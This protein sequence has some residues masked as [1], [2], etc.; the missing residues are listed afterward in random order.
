MDS[1]F[2]ALSTFAGV[3][4]A[5]T[6]VARQISLGDEKDES[7]G[8]NEYRRW[9]SLSVTYE[10]GA[11]ALFGMLYFARKVS[12]HGVSMAG[13]F[14]VLFSLMGLGLYCAYFYHL[15]ALRGAIGLKWHEKILV[16]LAL[17]PMA[18]FV[19]VPMSFFSSFSCIGVN[20]FAA[21]LAWLVLSGTS[22]SLIWY[23]TSWERP[24]TDGC[25]IEVP[26]KDSR[27]H[28]AVIK[29]VVAVIAVR[30]CAQASHSRK[31]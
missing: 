9:D 4:F 15:I 7:R 29:M 20:W 23:A 10:L 28:A 13:V 30:S 2:L 16:P 12:L 27:F 14:S 24:D 3:L 8:H 17:V 25:K 26:K 6:L 5:I 31:P 18:V 21:S 22:Q 19:A 1:Y 11:A